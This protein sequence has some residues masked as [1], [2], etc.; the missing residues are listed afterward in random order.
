[1]SVT[2]Y[3]W[4]HAWAAIG[5]FSKPVLCH[6]G[7]LFFPGH[8]STALLFQ[9]ICGCLLFDCVCMCMAKHCYVPV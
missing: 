8:M 4:H 1:M 2:L 3:H 5:A 6:R 7:F 9:A